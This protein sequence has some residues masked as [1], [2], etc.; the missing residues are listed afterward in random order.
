M[1]VL[2]D[3]MRKETVASIEETTAKPPDN[4]HGTNP[5]AGYAAQ[6][7]SAIGSQAVPSLIETL[8]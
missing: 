2:I 3:A 5:T 8:E 6:A 4:L 1:P 7:L